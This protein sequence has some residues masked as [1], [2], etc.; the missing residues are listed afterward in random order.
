MIKIVSIVGAR[1]QFIKVAVID[2]ACRMNGHINHVI[3]H[4]GQHYDEEMSGDFFSGLGISKP[5]YNFNINNLSHGA[6]TGRMIEKTEEVLIH[7]KPSAAFVYGDT[8]ST[9][10]GA[11]AAKKL[12]LPLAHIEA[13]LRNFNLDTPEEIN[14]ILTDR[15]SNLLFCPTETSV[16]NLRSEGFDQFG[17]EIHL[18]GDIMYDAHKL[19]GDVRKTE[20]GK[21]EKPF[22]LLTI[23]REEML[24]REEW[25]SNMATAILELNRHIRVIFP[26]HPRT[27]QA[28]ERIAPSITFML[29]PFNYREMCNAIDNCECVI[30][31]SGGLQKEAYFFKKPCITMRNSTEWTELTEAGVNILAGHDDINLLN[32]I[33]DLKRR[34]L[35]FSKKIFGE[36]KSHQLIIDK[37][38]SFIERNSR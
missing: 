18:V 14:R 8:N 26:A 15:I 19:F 21:H 4:T 28:I 10:A 1:P 38:I 30:T 31:D 11:L 34:N 33:N 27:R 36:G 13:G 3:I 9:L 37:T 7:E 20:Q 2:Y 23:H 25:L 32:L 17:C 5:A 29:P 22:I 35:D 24:Q 12:H 16:K 6:M